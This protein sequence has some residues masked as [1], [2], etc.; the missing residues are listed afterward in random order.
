MKSVVITGDSLSVSRYDYDDAP[1]FNAWDCH[2]G[3]GSWSFTLREKFLAKAAQFRYADEL[4]FNQPSVSG[5]SGDCDPRDAI[6]GEQ[7]RTITPVN[8]RIDFQVESDSGILVL[9][10]QKRTEHYCRFSLTVDGVRVKTAVDT[11]GDPSRYQGYDLLPVE[12]TCDNTLAVHTVVLSDFEY[13][14]DTPL[15]TLAGVSAETV[16][17]ALTGQGSRTAKFLCYHFEERIAA[18]SPDTLILI[19]G[20]NDMLFYSAEEYRF[21]LKNLFQKITGQF[22]FCRLVTLT[23]PPT[24][25]PEGTING[26]VYVTQQEWD[27]N[28]ETYNRVMRELSHECGAEMIETAN[29]FRSFPVSEWRYDNVHLTKRGNALLLEEVCKR[30][31]LS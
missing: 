15:V 30:L 26:K 12:V 19:F 22:P 1:R 14:D 8:D 3:M 4:R 21:Y 29:V 11:Y 20:G 7:I 10:F 25:M 27:D 24:L 9:Y 23:I 17:V 18:Y 16:S 6:F 2:I 28:Q 31:H 13:A 5:L